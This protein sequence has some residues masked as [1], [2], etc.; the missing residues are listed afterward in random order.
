MIDISVII[1]VY[2][3]EKYLRE[4]LDSVVYQSIENIEIICVDDGSKDS[5]LAILQEYAAIDK[6]IKIFVQ[7]NKGAGAARNYGMKEASGKYIIFLDSDDIYELDMLEK[8]YK[9]A[10]KYDLDVVVC[11]SD[12]FISNVNFSIANP[13]AIK[14]YLLPQLE[15][16]SSVDVEKNFFM[17][18]I[19]WPWD[20]L[21]KREYV[22]GL[23]IEFQ[24][25]RTTNDLYFIAS[26]VLAANCISYI[27][28]VLAH[29]RIGDKGTLSVTREKSWDCFKIALDKLK[30]FMKQKGLFE[31]FERDF[32]NY[33]LHFSLWQLETLK[34]R[35]YILLY[36]QLRKYWLKNL[37]I[38]DKPKEYFYDKSLHR[39]M[40]YIAENV[41]IDVG[42]GGEHQQPLIIWRYYYFIY[43]QY[44]RLKLYCIGYG[45]KK[46]IKKIFQVLFR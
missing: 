25:L 23:D 10:E 14:K 38:L 28:E 26:A 27:D 20:K 36:E 9:K 40:L 24:Q 4:C 21:F 39:M 7:S 45:Y 19:W 41:L 1:P 18:F 29:H 15:V 42:I 6:R 16:F 22:N 43:S 17:L 32:V 44:M 2:N 11:G 3:V 31:R 8:L 37:E 30:L 35:S 13:G 5:S 46:T 33:C 34:G 12:K